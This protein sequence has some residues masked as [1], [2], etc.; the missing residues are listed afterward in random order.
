MLRWRGSPAPR[1]RN[2]I[3][4]IIGLGSAQ[5]AHRTRKTVGCPRCADRRAQLHQRLGQDP[6]G[7]LGKNRS[8]FF[9]VVTR[10]RLLL[11]RLRHGV[12]PREH[13]RHVPIHQR[14]RLVECYR[15]DRPR[16]IRPHPR[17][18]AQR[19][20]FAGQ[21]ATQFSR[22]IS[23]AAM[24]QTRASIV[25]QA[26]PRPEHV[27]L[28]RRCQQIH[29]REAPQEIP[30]IGLYR[31]DPRLLQHDLRD[32]NGVRVPRPPPAQ[33]TLRPFKPRFKRASQLSRRGGHDAL[34]PMNGRPPG[35]GAIAGE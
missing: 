6:G 32:P 25:A 1:S 19:L 10:L 4:Q 9:P 15:R 33:V 3:G 23:R 30:V 2:L 17:N 7:P 13:A 18:T 16:G 35:K 34:M 28:I 14:L 26:T 11:R 20:D 29:G 21:L 22:N 31:L 12:D 27:I 24:K 8:R 5:I